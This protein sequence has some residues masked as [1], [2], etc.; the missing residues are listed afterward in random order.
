M[1]PRLKR[2]GGPVRS[3]FGISEVGMFCLLPFTFCLSGSQRRR[4]RQCDSF[5]FDIGGH[6]CFPGSIEWVAPGMC[7]GYLVNVRRGIPVPLFIPGQSAWP[8]LH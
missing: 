8:R 1:F 3:P 4:F 7:R 5:C 2:V 6:S